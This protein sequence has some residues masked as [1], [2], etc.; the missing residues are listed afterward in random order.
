MRE[1]VA[2]FVDAVYLYTF[3]SLAI[4]GAKPPRV[5]VGVKSSVLR[6]KLE[7][8]TQEIAPNKEILRVY[9]Y[10][11]STSNRLHEE[12]QIAICANDKFKLRPVVL[13]N[14][15]V[16]TGIVSK[17]VK[18]MSELAMNGGCSD[19][20]IIARND[21]LR[22]GV[23][24]CQSFGVKV[25]MLEVFK[26][27]T[28]RFSRLQTD[29]DS[30]RSWTTSEL[31]QV[32][33]ERELPQNDTYEKFYFPRETAFDRDSFNVLSDE[34]I[35]EQIYDSIEAVIRRYV[36]NLD[37]A[38]LEECES[39]W[40]EGGGGVPSDHD[41]GLL[42]E[43]RVKIDRNLSNRERAVMRSLF[44]NMINNSITD[45]GVVPDDDEYEYETLY[46][47]DY[48]HDDVDDF[49]ESNSNRPY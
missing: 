33:F 27:A 5:R 46:T 6:E 17:I 11:V 2:V 21:F 16:K 28:A 10:D 49:D 40:Q 32:L 34:E 47:G 31:S 18:D 22:P 42:N 30:S 38:R 35:P 9:W 7:Q 19:C 23:E 43:C 8:I 4:T 26:D 25:H 44:R 3:G 48:D 14:N 15:I 13:H 45:Q 37:M 24:I 1:N 41:K 29:V 36:S 20:L 39:F 12:A